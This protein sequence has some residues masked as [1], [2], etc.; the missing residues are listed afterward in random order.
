MW[1]LQSQELLQ[2]LPDAE[3]RTAKDLK[4]EVKWEAS[5][6]NHWCKCQGNFLCRHFLH[7]IDDG[8]TEH[9]EK[10]RSPSGFSSL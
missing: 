4:N 7:L 1:Y 6:R 8:K 10:V 9:I 3:F 2:S 5:S